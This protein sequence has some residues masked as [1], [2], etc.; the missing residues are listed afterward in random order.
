MDATA[1]VVGSGSLTGDPEFSIVSGAGY[2]IPPGGTHELVIRFDCRPIDPGDPN[3]ILH[4]TTCQLDEAIDV[5]LTG[6]C[7][8]T[9]IPDIAATPSHVYFGELWVETQYKRVFTLV[10]EGTAE[11]EITDK[12]LRGS[13][14]DQFEVTNADMPIVLAPGESHEVTVRFSPTSTGVKNAHMRFFSNDPDENPF[15]VTFKGIGKGEPGT[16]DIA[17]SPLSLDFGNVAVS[18]EFAMK[19]VVKN[20]G[21]AVLEVDSTNVKGQDADQWKVT[22][23]AAPF[24]I[25]PGDSHE[26]TIS[27]SP[28]T[29]GA[30]S[31]SLQIVSNDPDENPIEVSLT[32]N[33][34]IDLMQ[35]ITIVFGEFEGAD[36]SDVTYDAYIDKRRDNFNMGAEDFLR[37]GNDGPPNKRPNRTLIKFDF[38]S[39]LAASGVT[40]ASQILDARLEL[41]VYSSEGA[42]EEGLSVEIFRLLRDWEEGNTAYAQAQANEVTWNSVKHESENWSTSGAGDV[43]NDRAE[44]P[45]DTSIVN[46]IGKVD[47]DVTSSVQYIFENSMNYGWL[48]QAQ[49]ESKDN[50][51]RFYS[52]E[53]T[54]ISSRPKLTIIAKVTSGALTHLQFVQADNS[55]KPGDLV[56]N[57]NVVQQENSNSNLPTDFSLSQNYPN[58]FNPE[59]QIRFALPISAIVTIN[60]Y[61]IRG[62]VIK[63]LLDLN[64]KPS[65]IHTVIWDGRNKEGSIISSGMYFYR[66]LAQPQNGERKSYVQTK[67]L[68]FLK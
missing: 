29:E 9:L 67:K 2:D 58:P 16:Q 62:R 57:L 22:D 3:T 25:S 41:D 32:G 56:S 6:E 10:N 63:T 38:L 46:S 59:T 39:G 13:N 20:E 65:G 48:L 15:P 55:N 7:V 54:K 43:N 5:P 49:D 50:Y 45:D 28:T 11:L 1:N 17:V 40:E 14:G 4:L 27:M 47:W 60:V 42:D 37:V 68:I 23:G 53:H 8:V 19:V 52:R 24:T 26:V 64:F 34:F 21:G 51:Y 35:E 66:I 30:K 36:F 33:G 61:D 12:K 44:T 31:A 18:K